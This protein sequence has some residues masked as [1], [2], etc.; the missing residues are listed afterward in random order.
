MASNLLY[1]LVL[2]LQPRQEALL[3]PTQG[4]H[5]YALLLQIVKWRDA[6]YASYLHELPGAKPFTVSP[7]RGK[8]KRQGNY[9]LVSPAEVYRLR[10]TVLQEEVFARLLDALLHLPGDRALSLEA[11]AFGLR[12]V[13]TTPAESPWAGFTS[14]ATLLAGARP[15]RRLR[16]AFC[17]PTAFRSEGRRN[18][19]LPLPELVFGSLLTR[20]NEF[21]PHSLPEELRQ[22]A[23]EELLIARYQL[24]TR[25]LDFG[26]YKELGFEGE[27]EYECGPEL[28]ATRAAQLAALAGFAFYAGVGAKTTMGMGQSTEVTPHGSVVPRGAGLDSTQER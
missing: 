6:G 22:A 16:L 1:S 4:Y 23:K 10:L 20:W 5:A 17:S 21:A 12:R 15:R 27:C 14:F 25:M 9:V 18:V 28:P 11:A 3:A 26:R 24:R 8:V 2:E 19:V 7:L 13:V